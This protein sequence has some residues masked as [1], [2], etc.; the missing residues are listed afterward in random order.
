MG[1][2]LIGA[3]FSAAAV[4]T[5]GQAAAE[6][7]D[8]G[9][10]MPLEFKRKIVDWQGGYAGLS[11]ALEEFEAA[12][13]TLNMP[14]D[15]VGGDGRLAGLIG[16]YSW[17]VGGFLVGLEADLG[18]G[19]ADLDGH[20][21]EKALLA[22]VRSRI[23]Y[24]LGDIMP[25]ATAGVAFAG[26]SLDDTP[27]E[28]DE[29]DYAAG[30]VVGAGLEI[31]IARRLSGRVEYLYGRFWDTDLGEKVALDFEDFHV[32]RAGLVYHWDNR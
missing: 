1:Q 12:T 18:F 3:L 8:V 20:E 28:Y 5:T 2:K 24:E 15:I 31:T 23:G 6:D 21:D 29:L 4:L 7:I 11:V 16:G 10:P 17:G 26:L 25:Y 14:V 32:I 27:S 13:D 30:G 9:P 22:T 19:F